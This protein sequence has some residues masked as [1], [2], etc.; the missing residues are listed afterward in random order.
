VTPD[1]LL[2]N[3][4]EFVTTHELVPGASANIPRWQ[5]DLRRL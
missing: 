1:L 4:A 2:S 3:L 5:T